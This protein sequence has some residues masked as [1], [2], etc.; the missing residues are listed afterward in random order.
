M[1]IRRCLKSPRIAESQPLNNVLASQ[2]F[3]NN[4]HTNTALRKPCFRTGCEI[5]WSFRGAARYQGLV[6]TLSDTMLSLGTSEM[7]VWPCSL[8]TSKLALV[9]WTT[10]SCN[11]NVLRVGERDGVYIHAINKG[12]ITIQLHF[13]K[14]C[15]NSVAGNLICYFTAKFDP[16]MWSEAWAISR[17]TKVTK[18]V[19]LLIINFTILSLIDTIVMIVIIFLIVSVIVR[20]RVT[21]RRGVSV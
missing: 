16:L 20:V 21:V 11:F 9:G 5:A 1:V 13:W 4:R 7:N 17:G 2:A 6:P 19:E 15:D 10:A 12:A 8:I 18:I 14:I 3:P